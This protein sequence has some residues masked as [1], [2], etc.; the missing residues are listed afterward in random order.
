M[1]MRL[2]IEIY[3]KHIDTTMETMGPDKDARCLRETIK[4][5]QA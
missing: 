1:D 2:N 5:M 4:R 3:S